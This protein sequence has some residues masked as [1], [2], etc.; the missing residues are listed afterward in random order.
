[1]ASHW[2][3]ARRCWLRRQH[4]HRIAVRLARFTAPHV[5]ARLQRMTAAPVVRTAAH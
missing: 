3:L 5:A 2:T 1:M 4:T